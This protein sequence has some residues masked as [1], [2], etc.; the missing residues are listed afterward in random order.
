MFETYISVF[1][2]FVAVMP[3]FMW[4]RRRD[5]Q[6]ELRR[7]TITAEELHDLLVSDQEIAIV[8][9]RVPLDFLAHTEMIPGAQRI[10]PREIAANPN[11]LS[12]DLDY[13][14]VCT[15]PSEESTEVV[16]AAARNLGFLK[17]RMLI[18]GLETWKQKGYPVTP[19][20]KP[21]QLDVQ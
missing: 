13:V 15:C 16:L 9:L 20:D 10:S 5:K 12:K 7:H 6:R 19:Y 18:G 1:A 8:D 4:K 11:L 2:V 17:I 3:G 14:L 21:F